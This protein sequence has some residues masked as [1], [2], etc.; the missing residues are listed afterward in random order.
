[1]KAHWQKKNKVGPKKEVKQQKIIKLVKIGKI[2]WLGKKGFDFYLHHN[3]L[4]DLHHFGFCQ[5]L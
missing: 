5:L 2:Y 3:Q 4:A 1:M